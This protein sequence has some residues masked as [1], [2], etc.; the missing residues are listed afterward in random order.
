LDA[1]INGARHVVN[2]GKKIDANA[3][4]KQLKTIDLGGGVCTD[5]CS[6]NEAVQFSQY[7]SY[8]R[9]QVPEIFSG[10]F[11][12][13]TEF[14]RS[15]FTK[16]GISLSKIE[17][18]KDWGDSITALTHFG[19]NQFIREAYVPDIISHRISIFDKQGKPS[20]APIVEQDVAGPLCF[21]GDYLAKKRALPR[22]QSGQYLVMHDTGGYTYALYSRYNSIL[23]PAAYGYEKTAENGFKF[24]ELKARETYDEMIKFWGNSTMKSLN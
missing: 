8:L 3:G 24:Y 13:I 2:L 14:G 23:A 22:M 5:Y 9:E 10:Q 7:S 16:N 6:D 11:H 1:I 4:Q 15:V 21:Q 20:T 17:T 12:I 19:S 18:V